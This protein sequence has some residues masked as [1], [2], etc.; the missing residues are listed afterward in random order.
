MVFLMRLP[1]IVAFYYDK[2]L[3]DLLTVIIQNTVL[4]HSNSET[5]RMAL[6]YGIILYHAIQGKNAIEL[7]KN[8]KN[9]SSY[10]P[11]VFAIYRA[12][13][14]DSPYFIYEK[15]TL[16]DICSEYAGSVGFAF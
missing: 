9:R 1:G 6:I 12:V 16:D 7:Y 14:A 10:S 15:Y 5:K 3:K 4:T 11:L 8:I 13:E 2:P